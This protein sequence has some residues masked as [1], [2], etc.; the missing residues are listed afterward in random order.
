MTELRGCSGADGCP[1]GEAAQQLA[2]TRTAAESL[3]LPIPDSSHAVSVS[4]PRWADNVGYE[5]GELRVTSQ[6]QCGYPRFF[7][8]PRVRELFDAAAARSE[9]SAKSEDYTAFV[10]PSRKVAIRCAGFVSATRGRTPTLEAFGR[11][12][13]WAVCL[14]REDSPAAMSFWQHSGEIVTSRMAEAALS[15]PERPLLGQDTRAENEPEAGSL[16]DTLTRRLGEWIQIEPDNIWLYPSGMAAVAAAHRA[17]MQLRPGIRTV[18][19]GFPYVDILKVQQHFGAGVCFLPRGDAADM[20]EL[21]RRLR[22]GR[23]SAVFCEIPGN[24]L[25]TCPD[26]PALSALCRA[27]TVPLIVDDTLGALFNTS[28]HQWADVLVTSLTKYFSGYGDVMAGALTVNPASP[29]A[30]AMRD[31][32]GRTTENLLFA[33]DARVLE[34]NSR[35]A[36]ERI[37]QIN[38]TAEALC[39]WLRTRQEVES[40]AFP[41]FSTAENFAVCRRESGG[42]GGLFS[43]LLTEASNRTARFYDALDVCRGPNLGTNFTLCCPYTLLAHY[44]ELEFA[45]ERGV[46]RWLLRFSVGLESFDW[47]KERFERAFAASAS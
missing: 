32:V 38:A 37:R 13:L 17:I 23:V 21:E 45:E 26:L 36:P 46:S 20:A 6:M 14:P 30:D 5:E 12:G 33:E 31:A 42:Y 3:G 9:R 15:D 19:L 8:H 7:L 25:L 35:D 27:A 40:V 22:E 18:Q 39:D 2:E 24:P 43:L 1:A 44:G 29:L 16:T 11:T 10:F 34:R 41:K 47:L 4:L 28:L